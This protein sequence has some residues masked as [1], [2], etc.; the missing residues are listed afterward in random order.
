MFNVP[1]NYFI[2]PSKI[3][4]SPK[5]FCFPPKTGLGR[6]VFLPAVMVDHPKY[7]GTRNLWIELFHSLINFF[8]SLRWIRKP[9]QFMSSLLIT[10]RKVQIYNVDEPHTQ[11]N[12]TTSFGCMS[13]CSNFSVLV[14]CVKRCAVVYRWNCLCDG[15]QTMKTWAIC[16]LM[17]R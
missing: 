17:L 7:V 13:C 1:L 10:P 6:V 9:K 12:W 8:Q 16:K 14:S 2:F 5:E 3:S 4:R 11:R 15:K